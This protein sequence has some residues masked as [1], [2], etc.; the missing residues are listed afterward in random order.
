MLTDPTLVCTSAVLSTAGARDSACGPSSTVDA[1]VAI[2][3]APAPLRHLCAALLKTAQ[4][5]FALQ[6][7][8][9]LASKTRKRQQTEQSRSFGNLSLC[10]NADRHPWVL[11]LAEEAIALL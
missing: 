6:T 8:D 3:L 7:V 5:A 4:A 9:F 10:S 2:Q 11:Q 1:Y